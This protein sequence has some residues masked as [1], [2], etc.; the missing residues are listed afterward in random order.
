MIESFNDRYQQMFPGKVI[1]LS[2]DNLK[3]GSLAFEQRHNSRHRYSKLRGNTPLKAHAVSNGTLRFPTEDEAPMHQIK[4]PEI[5]RYHVVRLVRGDMKLNI[6]GEWF[7]VPLGVML[8]C[9]V[10]TIDLQE[11]KLFLNG[12]QM[13]EFDYKSH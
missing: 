7:S 4:K 11:Q 1:L 5:A 10:A 8:K 12:T 6:L 13:E 9:V 3:T 2:E